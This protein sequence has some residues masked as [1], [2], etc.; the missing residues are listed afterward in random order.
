MSPSL[1][2]HINRG[3]MHD[4][5]HP[6]D[7]ARLRDPD[8]VVFALSKKTASSLLRTPMTSGSSQVVLK[9]IQV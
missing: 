4:A 9:F 7:R 3:G 8:H 5:V 6:R 1:S 2:Q